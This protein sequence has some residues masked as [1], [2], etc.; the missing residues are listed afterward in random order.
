MD[1]FLF[2]R[3]EHSCALGENKISLEGQGVEHKHHTLF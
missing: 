1:S 3:N 2:A